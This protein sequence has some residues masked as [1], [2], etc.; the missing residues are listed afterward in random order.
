[1]KATYAISCAALILVLGCKREAKSPA[2][3]ATKVTN[4]DFTFYVGSVAVNGSNVPMSNVTFRVVTDTN[5]LPY[6][7][8]TSK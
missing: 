4:G 8:R 7:N 2:A 6:T 1:M 3:Q 5:N